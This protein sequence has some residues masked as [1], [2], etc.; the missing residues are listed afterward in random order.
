[1]RFDKV[2]LVGLVVAA[3]LPAT[4][5]LAQD[6]GALLREGLF[7]RDRNVS[8]TER[9]KPE[10]NPITMHFGSFSVLPSITGTVEE[11]DNIYATNSNTTSDTIFRVNPAV[12]ARSNWNRHALSLFANLTRDFYS[13][14]SS[15]ETTDYLVGFDGR[16]DVAHDLGF[17]GG[18]SYERDTEPRT[19]SSSPANATKPVQFDVARAYG[20]GTYATNRIRLSGR[21]SVDDY[22]FDNTNTSTGATIVEKDRD[23]TEWK[24]S[25]K[26]EYALV[27]DTSVFIQGILNQRSYRNPQAGETLRDSDGYTVHVGANFDLTHL[28]RG[29]IG[30]GYLSQDY[31]AAI[32]SKSSGFSFSGLVEWFPTQ[33]T[34]VTFSGNRG[35]EDAGIP[36]VGGYLST[37]GAISIDHELL[38]NIIVNGGLTYGKDEYQNYDRTDERTGAHIGLKYLMNRAVTINVAYNYYKQDSSGSKLGA[39]FDVNRVYASL[40]Y[41]F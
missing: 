5:A 39:Q 33:L 8:V 1:M 29:E 17:A 31:D 20:E 35:V 13:S 3:M 41:A 15:E 24:E 4:Q 38:R 34:T 7:K 14:H 32:Y 37:N 9:P 10:Y 27:P 2:T 36:N 22:S 19:S 28:I 21:V 25:A 6:D 23:H 30:V 18:A 11:N 26:L 40:A 16:L 12:V